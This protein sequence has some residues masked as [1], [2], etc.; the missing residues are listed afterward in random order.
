MSTAPPTSAP[1]PD[2]RAPLATA[3]MVSS[4]LELLTDPA[5]LA[6]VLWRGR[7][8]VV[9]GVVFCLTVACLY[10]LTAKRLYQGTAKILVLEHGGAP[11][12][13]TGDAARFVRGAEDDIPTHAALVGSPEVVRQAIEEIGLN[14]LPS[15][16]TTDLDVATRAVMEDLSVS[17]PDR[18]AKILQISFL[19]RSPEEATRVVRAV[20]DSYRAFLGRVYAEG[21]SRVVELMS[22]ARDDLSRELKDLEAKYV[23][24]RQKTPNLTAGNGRP[25]V[26]QRVEEWDKAGR[27]A[28]VRAVR[29]KSQLELGRELS[30]KGV[31]LWAITHA[32]D[33]LGG[34]GDVSLR[35]QSLGPAAPSDYLRLL[36]GE[37][38]RYAEKLGPQS[39]KVKEI[40]EQI[41][42][43]QADSR[44]NRG[45]LEEAEVADLLGSV[46]KGLKSIETMRADMKEQFEKD[47][48]LA[49]EAEIDLLTDANLKSEVDR[50]RKLFDTVVEQL[51]RATLVGDYAGTRSHQIEPPN[52]ALKPV[53]PRV[54]LTLMMALAAGLALGVTAAVG[55]ELIDPRL[56]SAVEAGKVTGLSLL[57]PVPFAPSPEG[58]VGPICRALPRSPSAEAYRVIRAHV[59][60]VRRGRDFKVILV[61]SPQGGE[62]A[63]TVAAN[64]ATA[65]AHAGRR[66]LL[67]DADLRNPSQH[68]T[69]QT[70]HDR[71][72]VHML[73]GLLPL[74][75]VAQST[76]VSQLDLVP[77][78]PEIADPAELFSG[79]GLIETLAECRRAYDT[80]IIDAP[81]LGRGVDAALIGAQA[82]AALLV[83][84]LPTTTRTDAARAVESLRNL[85]ASILGLVVNA[86][87]P[88]T[89]RWPFADRLAPLLK[90]FTPTPAPTDGS[91]DGEI[92][93]DPRISFPAGLAFPQVDV[94]TSAFDWLRPA[95]EVPAP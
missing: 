5:G 45:R 61:T 28:M 32:L 13:T 58:A 17:R 77:C 36:A 66:T 26:H 67:V 93:Y 86:S 7:K 35:T 20:A 79:D 75:R 15:L 50:Q 10:L 24:F 47:L 85:G 42:H 9:V 91:A 31:G 2:R 44:R 30:R 56:R 19:A 16:G 78:G 33:Q 95:P 74:A 82:D 92:P 11:L 49:K 8:F 89:E 80:V 12:A 87:A 54:S 46:E 23:E 76:G 37:Q 70:S 4:P 39:T 21:N 69:F 64:L 38:Q 62:G 22:K 1:T 88:E 63:S 3:A 55:S 25:F 57:G 34:A 68:R 52:A 27:D 43:L 53:R 72:V 59:D 71:G 6:A 65:C 48:A 41:S 94:A 90:R 18:L 84:R 73:R 14:N 83:V 40:E 51:K 29:L 60:L 81:A